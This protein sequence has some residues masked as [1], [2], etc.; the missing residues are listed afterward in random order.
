M[1]S[2]YCL[3]LQ[4][5]KYYVGKTNHIDFRISDHFD[6][7]GSEWTKK[8]KPIDIVEIKHN[9]DN[10]DE[11]KYTKIFMSKYGIDNVRGGS[12]TKLILPNNVKDLLDKELKSTNDACFKCGKIG[13]YANDCTNVF[14][15]TTSKQ[16]NITCFNCGK[17]GHYANNCISN[18]QSSTKEYHP[19]VIQE[20]KSTTIK[21]NNTKCFNCGK[22]GHYANDCFLRYNKKNYV[23]KSDSEDDFDDY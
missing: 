9:C 5:G 22:I 12:Y 3:K 7:N 21:Q 11:D 4:Y 13:H 20:F 17:I 6:G 10:F 16:N 14:K 8:Y 18:S 1:V 19:F 15:S 2:I 23:S